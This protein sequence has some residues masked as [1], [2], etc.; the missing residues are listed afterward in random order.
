MNNTT[1][2]SNKNKEKEIIIMTE[3]YYAVSKS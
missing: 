1:K 3:K 2:D